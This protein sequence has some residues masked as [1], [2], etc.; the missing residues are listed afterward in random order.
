VPTLALISLLLVASMC[1][2]GAQTSAAPSQPPLSKS[3]TTAV[4]YSLAFPGAGQ[5]YTERYWK[6][7]IFAG[8]AIATAYLTVWNQGQYA[9]VDRQVDAAV[10]SG[11]SSL[12]VDR[13]RRSRDV[14]RQNRDVSG[15]LLLATYLIAAVDAYVGAHLYDFN[16]D[17]SLSLHVGPS[18][19]APVAIGMA[20]RW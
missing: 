10:A 18:G 2:L 11:E 9:D 20:L 17:E 7:P 14:F 15:A 12:S 16:V 4:L 6:V 5:V 1:S 8:A 19:T 3:P 13:L